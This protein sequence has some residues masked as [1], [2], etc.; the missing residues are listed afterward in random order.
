MILA[1]LAVIGAAALGYLAS[2]VTGWP[3]GLCV[4][5]GAVAGMMASGALADR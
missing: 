1:V 5:I 2:V 4:V 3:E